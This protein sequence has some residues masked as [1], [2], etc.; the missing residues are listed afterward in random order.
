MELKTAFGATLKQVRLAR[1]LVQEDFALVS[2]RTNISLLERSKTIP[3]LE[4]ME[5]LCALMNLHPVTLLAACYMK[6]EGNGDV[7]NFLTVIKRELEALMI[8]FDQSQARAGEE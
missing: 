5:E 6:K 2:S 7:T 1:N 4:K 3:T 8:E